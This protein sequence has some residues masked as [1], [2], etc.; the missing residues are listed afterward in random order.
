M[1]SAG[2]LRDVTRKFA[3][4]ARCKSIGWEEI[5]LQY[6]LERHTFNNQNIFFYLMKLTVILLAS[7]GSVFEGAGRALKNSLK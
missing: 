1:W 5:H 4:M 6:K 2:V 7:R 3:N